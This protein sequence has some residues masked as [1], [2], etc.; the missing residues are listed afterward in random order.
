[1]TRTYLVVLEKTKDAW[2][3]FSPDVPGTG[4]MGD[5]VDEARKSLRDGI[6]YMLDYCVEKSLPFPEASSIV[7]F[8]EFTPN[9]VESHYE[10]E[11]MTVDLPEVSVHAEDHAKQAA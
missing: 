8:S 3:A 1:M 7:N 6:G 2:G 5:T 10:I 9:P 11:W 4:G